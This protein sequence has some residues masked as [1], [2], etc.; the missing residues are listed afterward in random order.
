GESIREGGE[1]IAVL[2]LGLGCNLEQIGE[3]GFGCDAR[4]SKDS[5]DGGGESSGRVVLLQRESTAVRL[6]IGRE[7]DLFGQ[8]HAI[9]RYSNARRSASGVVE[10]PWEVVQVVS[11]FAIVLPHSKAEVAILRGAGGVHDFGPIAVPY[12]KSVVHRLVHVRIGA[13]VVTLAGKHHVPHTHDGGPVLIVIIDQP[14]L[15]VPRAELGRP[16]RRLDRFCRQSTLCEGA[17][18]RHRK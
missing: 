12:H 9:L 3:W 6:A 1:W 13:S 18:S 11:S 15:G 2:P 5:F 14:Q 17:G 10:F 4:G 7:D 16:T 8:L